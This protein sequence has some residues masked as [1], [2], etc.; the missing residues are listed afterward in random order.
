MDVFNYVHKK[1]QI[2]QNYGTKTCLNVQNSQELRPKFECWM[3]HL[4][5]APQQCIESWHNLASSDKVL[6]QC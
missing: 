5:A 3:Q 4:A 6:R 2:R 1:C